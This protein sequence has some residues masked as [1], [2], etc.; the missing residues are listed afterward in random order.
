MECTLIPMV[1]CIVYGSSVSFGYKVALHHCLICCDCASVILLLSDHILDKAKMLD[2]IFGSDLINDLCVKVTPG[3]DAWT[4]GFYNTAPSG[5]EKVTNNVS[6]YSKENIIKHITLINI[7]SDSAQSRPTDARLRW[8][9]MGPT[10]GLA[11]S[12]LV[13]Y[14]KYVRLHLRAL[15]ESSLA[16]GVQ[17]LEARLTVHSLFDLDDSYPNGHRDLDEPENEGDSWFNVLREEL[18]AFKANHPEFI[19]YKDIIQLKRYHSKQ[20]IEE[21]IGQAVR[22]SQKYPDLVRGID[23]VSE[24]D[25]GYS[26]LYFIDEILGINNSSNEHLQLLFHTTETNWPDDL[27]TS[28]KTDDPVGTLENAYD[29]IMLGSKRVGHGLGIIKHPYIM[30]LLRES[31]IAVEVNPVSN[32]VLGYVPD[33]RN[34]PAVTYIK[35]GIPVV[36]GADDPGSM[37]HNFFTV[38]WYEA[39]MGWGIR[40]KDMKLLAM[41]ALAFS[42]MNVNERQVATRKWSVAWDQFIADVKAEACSAGLQE[43]LPE[44]HSMFPSGSPVRINATIRVYG[45]HFQSAI[46]NKVICRFGN[47]DTEGEYVYNTMLKCKAPHTSPQGTVVDVRVSLDSGHSYLDTRLNY[48]IFDNGLK[49][50]PWLVPIVIG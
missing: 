45:R 34:H 42:T 9:E 23:L 10:F 15:F 2:I 28:S 31:K 13:R 27:I 8:Q 32:M 18:A 37:G 41:N 40:L 24:E 4:L 6:E 43:P 25:S 36:M 47:V 26:L 5:W 48:D 49:A 19:G 50:M 35:A 17:Y 22:L 21:A 7:L 44:V 16:E 12:D 11:G 33:M 14:H 20:Q 30:E 3:V 29:A 39:F 38:D 46:C 1:T